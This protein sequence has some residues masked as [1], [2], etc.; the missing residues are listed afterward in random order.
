MHAWT[1]LFLIH[2]HQPLCILFVESSEIL[3]T[4]NQDYDLVK[5]KHTLDSSV[6][7]N[8]RILLGIVIPDYI[9]N[10]SR[11]YKDLMICDETN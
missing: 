9:C 8:V 5:P 2:H 3:Q 7:I 6:F 4:E 10:H 11:R 1:I